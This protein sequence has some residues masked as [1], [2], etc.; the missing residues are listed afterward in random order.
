MLGASQ[1]QKYPQEWVDLPFGYVTNVVAK[2][3]A[4]GVPVTRFWNDPCD[5]RDAT[6]LLPTGEAIVWDEVLGWRIGGF[7]T[8]QRGVRTHLVLGTVRYFGD[9]VLPT[10]AKIVWC[11]T[12]GDMSKR[13]PLP[14]RSFTDFTDSF[15]KK[16]RR[17]PVLMVSSALPLAA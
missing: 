9:E 4:A 11:L 6:I 3:I 13:A 12:H 1:V 2:L 5:P 8:G 10:P 7:L 15:D 17:Y 16:L 14:Y